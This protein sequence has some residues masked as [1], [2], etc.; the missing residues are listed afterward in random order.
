MNII[1]KRQK[2]MRKKNRVQFYLKKINAYN[3]R[4]RLAV[5]LSERHASVQLISAD[6]KETLAYVSTQ[7]KWFKENNQEGVTIKSYNVSGCTAVGI[8]IASIL[9]KDF[10]D[11]LF[12]F[13]RGGEQY[14]K[15]PKDSSKKT[16]IGRV[17]AIA[18]AIRQQGIIL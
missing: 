11:K 5:Y 6:G 4:L 10:A 17:K 14:G 1:E 13:D 16:S 18:E 15:T 2:Q 3:D 7:Q 9:K 8:K 12:Y